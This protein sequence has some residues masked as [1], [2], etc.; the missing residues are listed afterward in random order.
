MLHAYDGE[1][2]ENA[3]NAPPSWV[4]FGCSKNM[5]TRQGA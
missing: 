2:G 3:M 4:C 5:P 1:K